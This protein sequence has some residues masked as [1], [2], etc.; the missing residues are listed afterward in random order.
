MKE[1]EWEIIGRS[2]GV[3]LKQLSENQQTIAQKLI[4]YVLFYGKKE[5]LTDFSSIL[6]HPASYSGYVNS[7]STYIPPNRSGTHFTTPYASSSP[8]YSS[9]STTSPQ[10]LSLSSSSSRQSPLT[11]ST[12][13]FTSAQ[14]ADIPNE[15][16]FVPHERSQQLFQM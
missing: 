10:A 5:R 3:Q 4:S 12:T 11:P 1:E 13:A 6:L 16:L 9:T 15:L 2:L 8:Q 14:Q 7:S